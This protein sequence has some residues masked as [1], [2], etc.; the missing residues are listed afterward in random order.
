[1]FA[2]NPANLQVRYPNS[3]YG[4]SHLAAYGQ[5]VGAGISAFGASIADALKERA[6]KREQLDAVNAGWEVVKEQM[7]ALGELD[8]KFQTGSL[9]A[10]TGLFTQA[11]AM[12][13]RNDEQA[14]KT[15]EEVSFP[16]GGRAVRM[17]G[18]LR[19][20]SDYEPP[21]MPQPYTLPN[22][23]SGY[24]DARGNFHPE[25]EYSEDAGEWVLAPDNSRYLHRR[26]RGGYTGATY[27]VGA[28]A[29]PQ[30]VA[31]PDP[32]TGKMAFFDNR[33]NLV[34]PD[35]LVDYEDVPGTGKPEQKIPAPMIPG[36]PLPPGYQF[37]APAVPPQRRIK[38]SA[39]TQQKQGGVKISNGPNGTIGTW[40]DGRSAVFDWETKQWIPIEQPGGPESPLFPGGDIRGTE[41]PP[42]GMLPGAPQ[43]GPK[44]VTKLW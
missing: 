4:A 3:D 19:P 26:Q 21:P 5:N 28:G 9:G 15:P 41:P 31:S 18:S 23:P 32:G 22:G 10:K 27:P 42:G 36:V 25:S 39:E 13:R 38:P 12:L 43:T 14:D 2:Y 33:G 30:L 6:G 37:T 35:K 29:P 17:G 20:A 44:P 34:D 24:V 8:E 40:P 1:M 16:G 7:P 11:L